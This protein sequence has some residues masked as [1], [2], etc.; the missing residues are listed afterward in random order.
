MQ[1]KLGEKVSELQK[2]ADEKQ[3]FKSLYEKY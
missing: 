2:E 3:K 1:A